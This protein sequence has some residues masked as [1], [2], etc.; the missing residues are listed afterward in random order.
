[1]IFTNRE[2]S[3]CILLF[4]FL[5]VERSTSYLND[6]DSFISHKKN[7]NCL[8]VFVFLWQTINAVFKRIIFLFI[9]ISVRSLRSTQTHTHCAHGFSLR[10]LLAHSL[11][12]LYRVYKYNTTY[13]F[14]YNGIM[15]NK[16]GQN[17]S[18][19]SPNTPKPTK[20]NLPFSSLSPHPNDRK[21][22]KFVSPF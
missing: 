22:K 6:R 19:A 10:Y 11:N 13:S 7:Y 12:Y 2:S 9:I 1:M 20:R 5:N 16:N 15:Y 18:L 3:K 14:I 8:I 4:F 21:S 17:S